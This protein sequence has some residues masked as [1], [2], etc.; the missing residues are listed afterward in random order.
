MSGVS[1]LQFITEKSFK[2]SVNWGKQT[3]CTII[4]AT[5]E[6]N[7]LPNTVSPRTMLIP[8]WSIIPLSNY[9]IYD[10]YIVVRY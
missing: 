9:N 7:V 1:P 4:S 8:L 5:V 3:V 2:P 6:R 10:I